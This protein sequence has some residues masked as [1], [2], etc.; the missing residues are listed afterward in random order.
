VEA[1]PDSPDHALFKAERASSRNISLRLVSVFATIFGFNPELAL[2][3][4]CCTAN[5]PLFR[6]YVAVWRQDATNEVPTRDR[7]EILLDCMHKEEESACPL[8]TPMCPVEILELNKNVFYCL[9]AESCFMMVPETL[10]RAWAKDHKQR[11]CRCFF[12]LLLSFHHS[13]FFFIQTS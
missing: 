9:N 1:T 3:H 4:G 12:R 8:A 13:Y 6:A 5:P 10:K 2:R 7:Q 11:G